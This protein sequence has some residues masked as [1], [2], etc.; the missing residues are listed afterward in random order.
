MLKS[1]HQPKKPS[2]DL[3]PLP[4]GW[5]EHKAPTGHAYYYN[6]ATKQSTYTR[7]IAPPQT[8]PQGALP[9]YP[10]S[11]PPQG[12]YPPGFPTY[13]V[14]TPNAGFRF[15][16][17]IGGFQGNLLSPQFS[18]GGGIGGRGG[19][20]GG[21]HQNRK[22]RNLPEDRPKSK[23]QIPGCE[24]WLLVKTKL[25]RRFFYHPEKRSSF[26]KIPEELREGVER[27]D[28][29][30]LQRTERGQESLGDGGQDGQTEESTAITSEAD[31]VSLKRTFA[32][33]DEGDE[34][35]TDE[36]EEADESE[37]EDE[38]NS[39]K[40]Q[41]T[42]DPGQPVEFNEDDIAWQLA[43]MGEG[44]GEEYNEFAKDDGSGELEVDAE[45]GLLSGE[46][47]KGL[48][49]DMLDDY[50]ISPYSTWDK[51]IEEGKVVEDERYKIL[52]N[53]RSRK[54]TWDEWSRERIQKLKEEKAIAEKKDPRI[55]YLEFLQRNA[56]PKLYWPE[57][58][59]KYK[60]EPEMRDSKLSDKD[61]E[62]WYRDYIA[63]IR[64]ISVPPASR[65]P[66]IKAYI[67]TL[68]A[69][70]Q[71][72]EVIEDAEQLQKREERERR[73]RA[74]KEREKMVL[75]E[76]M[77]VKGEIEMGKG[78]LREEEAQLE[79]AMKVGKEGLLGQLQA[80]GVIDGPREGAGEERVA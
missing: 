51:V 23:H 69:P 3:T 80:S 2:S 30:E 64:Y 22:D 15:D 49:K 29:A 33:V 44:G 68:P 13:P 26:W 27:F 55:P 77:R 60:K 5:T 75:R 17:P 56:T 20:R 43:A 1:T 54:E 31:A 16:A 38:D 71:A 9:P 79:R 66:L 76:K 6:A 34:E 47:S 37:E 58:K 46:D 35:D 65:D 41:K 45:D 61:R 42:R 78:R 24:P 59:R 39:T 53:M 18:H 50:L 72:S 11:N 19:F 28:K 74:L 73:E 7:P 62:K 67:S 10:V 21:F 63:H 40:R 52:P 8:Y 32:A 70:P 25:G 57:F 14:H 4:P 48:F 12:F 36:Y